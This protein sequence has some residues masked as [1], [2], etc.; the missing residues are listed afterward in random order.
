MPKADRSGSEIVRVAAALEEEMAQLEA[1]SRSVRKIRLDGDKNIA[2]AAAQLQQAIAS[3]ARL[4]ERLQE[5]AAAMA[6]LQ[7][8]QQ[9]ALEPLATFAQTIAQRTQ[10]F[11]EHMQSYGALG[12][13]AGELNDDLATGPGDRDSLARVEARL[14]DISDRARALFEAARADDFPEVARE[15]D[16]LKQRMAALRKRLDRPAWRA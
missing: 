12:R 15:A 11:E 16:V 4:A 1:V 14:Q 8:R 5:L 10:R 7:E 13:A 2:R 3:P 6:R 9:A